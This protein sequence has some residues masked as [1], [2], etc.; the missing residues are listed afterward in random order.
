MD[1][2]QGL[3]SDFTA[4]LSPLGPF[5]GLVNVLCSQKVIIHHASSCFNSK[6]G[7][8]NVRFLFSAWRRDCSFITSAF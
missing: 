3:Y 7:S 8:Y 5:Y 6:I 4:T 1:K 2:L